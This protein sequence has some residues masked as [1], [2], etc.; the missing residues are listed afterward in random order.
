M[1]Y[2]IKSQKRGISREGNT[3][4]LDVS[5]IDPAKLLF[6]ANVILEVLGGHSHGAS[7]LP[8]STEYDVFISHSAT[9]DDFVDALAKHLTRLGLKV[10]YDSLSFKN[11]EFLLSSMDKGM[12]NS[13]LCITVLSPSYIDSYWC[14]CELNAILQL[15]KSRDSILL[16][17]VWHHVQYAEVL[18]FSPIIASRKA[19]S[20]DKYSAAE[21]AIEVQ[22]Y[23]AA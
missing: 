12:E 22:H 13:R 2:T 3:D 11:G 6:L 14:C 7:E 18:K 9:E 17:P 20:T 5:G 1:Y 4:P 23:L 19:L 10:C 15:E 8:P 16:F 21:I